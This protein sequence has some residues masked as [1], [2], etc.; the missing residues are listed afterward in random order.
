M[1]IA[2][3][4]TLASSITKGTAE[5]WA[6]SAPGW[7]AWG[8]ELIPAIVLVAASLVYVDVYRRAARR[9]K[10]VGIGHSLPYAA[11]IVTVALA[12]FSPIDA[13]GDTWLLSMHMLQ[14]VL[15]ADI[16]PALIVVGLRSPLLPLGLPKQALIAIAPGG[17]YGR[18]VA[19][20]TSPWVLLPAW[21][22][23]TWVWVV[24]SI[25]DY[26]SQHSFVH[27]L[28]HATLFY[29]GL[30]LWWLVVDPLPRSRLRPNAV[31]LGM[32]GFTRIAAAAICVPLMWITHVE[33]PLYAAAP[34]AFGLS[35]IEDQR[36]AGAGMSFL[37]IMLFGIAFAVVFISVLSRADAAD[38]VAELAGRG[39]SAG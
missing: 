1:S 11:G 33:Y 21:V 39:Q 38:S 12:L 25:F 27:S 16:A 19:T 9:S 13:I 15:L 3:A 34:R 5:E 18:L 8:F 6:G 2:A 23:V 4:S 32:L 20:L 24:P 26:S 31:R 10:A 35:P 30:G 17:R 22:A 28:E 29:S 14:H 36:L 7:G 37:E